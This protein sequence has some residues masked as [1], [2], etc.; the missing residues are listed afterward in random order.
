LKSELIP[1]QKNGSSLIPSDILTSEAKLLLLCDPNNPLG[2]RIYPDDITNILSN[3]QQIIIIDEAY[4]EFSAEHS[5]LSW[6]TK[7]PNLIIIRTCSKALGMAGL[8]IGAIIATEKTINTLKRIQPPFNMPTPICSLLKEQLNNDSNLYYGIEMICH[9]RKRVLSAICD[10]HLI[11]KI[12]TSET[13]FICI[14]FHDLSMAKEKLS[15]ANI[16]VIWEPE[17]L[18]NTARITLGNA[19]ENNLL[20]KALKD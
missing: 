11:E 9:E 20:I 19:D 12:Y 4:V 2:T 17:G 6:I 7:N 18:H 1:L 15:T 8:R 10:N 13:N 3:F 14:E 5:A 16:Q